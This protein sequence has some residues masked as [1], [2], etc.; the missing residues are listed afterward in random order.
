MRRDYFICVFLLL[1]AC[2]LAFVCLLPTCFSYDGIILREVSVVETIVS[3]VFSFV[4]L[5]AAPLIIAYKRK[6]WA[7]LGMVCYG[8]LA[9]IPGMI[10][11]K[12]TDS[13]S[14]ADASIG[15]SV[16]ALLLKG[17][18]TMV[19]APFVGVG[20]IFGNDLAV[21]FSRYI[22][23]S[24]L[25]F[26]VVLKLFRFYRAAYIAEKMA[27]SP[28]AA[29]A[30]G[31]GQASETSK[32][33]RK[34]DILG[35]VISK[36]VSEATVTT[37]V[38][39]RSKNPGARKTQ[40]DDRT[41]VHRTVDPAIDPRLAGRSKTRPQEEGQRQ[42]QASRQA[43]QL[44]APQRPISSE[45]APKVRAPQINLGPPKQDPNGEPRR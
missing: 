26:Y 21:R 7:M 9:Y 37:R 5:L 34:P 3:L 1:T 17:V 4:V 8:L 45:G 40:A 22:I 31:E 15:A 29:F 23:P 2:S 44:G 33:P 35:T 24:A 38:P 13:L 20:K 14:G 12:M 28:A 42:A 25:I 32:P 43:I 41:M 6:L 39:D 16:K 19:N 30:A 10:I 18:Y 27:P 11:P 36:P